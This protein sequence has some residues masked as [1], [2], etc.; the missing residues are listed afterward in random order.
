[1]AAGA[2]TVPSQQLPR[3]GPVVATP[4]P[5][6]HL[7]VKRDKEIVGTLQD[8]LVSM[9]EDVTEFEITP[10]GRRITKLDQILRN[11]NNNGKSSL[12]KGC[13][14][15]FSVPLNWSVFAFSCLE[16]SF[17]DSFVTEATFK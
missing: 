5:R 8:E 11:G 13:V 17:P 9:L 14:H 1:M 12:L 4:L 15:L 3:S 10:K 6:V 2:S 16:Q 7:G